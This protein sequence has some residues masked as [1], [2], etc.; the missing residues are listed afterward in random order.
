MR[1]WT[2]ILETEHRTSTHDCEEEHP[3]PSSA[4]P[5]QPNAMKLE[6]KIELL[7]FF[8]TFLNT[9]FLVLGL[10][11][12]GCAIWILLGSGSFLNVLSSDELQV[13]AMGLLLI[14]AVVILV[15]LVGCIGSSSENRFMLVVYGSFLIVLVLGQLF[16]MLLLLINRG[17][18]NQALTETVHKIISDYGNSSDIEE[19]MMDAMQKTGRCCGLTRASDWLENSFLQ[20]LNLST[21]DVLPCSCYASYNLTFN[22]SWCSE[23]PEFHSASV[24]EG[25]HAFNESCSGK[26]SFWLQENILTIISMDVILLLLQMI[27]VAMA[28]ALYQMFGKKAT[29]KRN[30]QLFD[31]SQDSDADSEDDGQHTYAYIHPD[32]EEPE[33]NQ[34]NHVNPNQQAR[35]VH[36]AEPPGPWA[37]RD[38]MDVMSVLEGGR[39]GDDCT[40]ASWSCFFKEVKNKQTVS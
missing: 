8:F 37:F 26:L 35:F 1:K 5:H 30:N 29:L 16:V 6:V 27:D 2:L 7:K 32:G 23:N 19:R 34:T 12:G 4:A 9:L 40:D 13:V 38:Q 36:R 31:E 15:S 25:V 20:T 18:I 39:D 24:G 21:V 28:A 33:L 22:S 14:G 11:V 17:K 3:S 10:S